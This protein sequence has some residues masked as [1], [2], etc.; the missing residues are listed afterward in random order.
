MAKVLKIDVE[1]NAPAAETGLDRLEKKLQAAEKAAEDM[2]AAVDNLGKTSTKAGDAAKLHSD[3]VDMLTRR[4]LAFVSVGAVIGA[5]RNTAAWA[6]ELQTLSRTMAVGV[7]EVQRM[8]FAA[9]SNGS[10]IEQVNSAIGQLSQRL[11]GG[12][13]SAVEGLKRIGVSFREIRESNP[14]DAFQSIARAVAAIEDPMIQ[15]RAATELFGAAGRQLLPMLTSDIDAAKDKAEELGLVLDPLLVKK[16]AELDNSINGLTTKFKVWI[17]EGLEPVIPLLDAIANR[18]FSKTTQGLA[19]LAVQWITFG[20]M[21]KRDIDELQQFQLDR[22]LGLPLNDTAPK[23]PRSPNLAAPGASPIEMSAERERT[24]VAMLNHEFRLLNERQTEAAE[25]AKKLAQEEAALEKELRDVQAAARDAFDAEIADGF[26]DNMQGIRERTRAIRDDFAAMALSGSQL[27]AWQ[28]NEGASRE[29]DEID[30]RAENAAQA[31]SMLE[32]Q[33]QLQ[34]LM[35][36]RDTEGVTDELNFQFLVFRDTYKDV[37]QGLPA[38]L[39]EVIPAMQAGAA[40]MVEPLT[41]G[42]DRVGSKAEQTFSGVIAIVHRTSAELLAMSAQL[43]LD[44]ERNMQRGNAFGIGSFQRQD[45]ARMRDRAGYA[46]YSQ[47]MLG[48]ADGG[49][50]PYYFGAG[51]FVP[52]G[53]DTVPAMLTPG[54]GVISRR[55]M[56]AFDRLNRGSIGGLTINAPLVDARG[57]QFTDEASMDRLAEKLQQK[58][59]ETYARVS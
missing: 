16:A 41:D 18:D 22:M 51:G 20:A 32:A 30:P 8:D 42:F 46:A 39:G 6:D 9:K 58:L 14:V 10:S 47:S 49:I 35:L 3:G 40:A 48:F 56:D 45:A 4:V 12:D 36:K 5:V 59:Q 34:M 19:D 29:R 11:A 24:Q 57:A 13:A 37:L 50:V 27:K 2:D 33:R 44:A 17:A 52:R 55:G 1:L 38:T 23:L 28:I 31:A 25:A 43:E 26:M 54:E 21:T 15:A 53:T 7:A